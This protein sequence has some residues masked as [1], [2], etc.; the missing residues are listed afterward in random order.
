MS[1]PSYPSDN[2]DKLL[3]RFPEGLRDRIKATAE[4]N[5]RSMNAEIIAALEQV[6]P[7]PNAIS[8]PD[9]MTDEER[10]SVEMDVMVD[11]IRQM[12]QLRDKLILEHQ[13]RAAREKRPKS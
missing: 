3:L 6:F 11:I 10:H 9:E 7:D 4:A 1:R 8:F 13:I 2:V 12:D 5:K